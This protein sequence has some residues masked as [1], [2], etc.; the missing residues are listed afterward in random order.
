MMENRQN[1]SMTGVRM[2]STLCSQ[3]H[4]DWERDTRWDILGNHTFQRGSM[5]GQFNEILRL[6]FSICSK[7]IKYNLV[8]IQLCKST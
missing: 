3:L 5:F 8:I 4:G 6:R 7:R 2:T 1:L